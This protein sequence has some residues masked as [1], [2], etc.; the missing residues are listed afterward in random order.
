MKKQQKTVWCGR[1]RA[2][3]ELV[4]AG[5]MRGPASEIGGTSIV[6]LQQE[7]TGTTQWEISECHWCCYYLTSGSGRGVRMLKGR[8]KKS[9]KEVGLKVRAN[10]TTI[11]VCHFPPLQVPPI[12]GLQ[13]TGNFTSHH[14]KRLGGR[15]FTSTHS[16]PEAH[17]G[18]TWP[19][20]GPLGSY[21]GPAAL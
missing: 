2:I 8:K 5:K 1:P 15:G 3:S 6:I 13:G 16:R 4:E 20:V 12:P 19:V 17:P 10:G 18:R 11:S 21:L 9:W 14:P 7:N